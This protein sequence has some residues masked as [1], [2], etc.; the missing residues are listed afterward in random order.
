MSMSMS[1]KKLYTY[2]NF[3]YDEPG[4]EDSKIYHATYQ[5]NEETI[6]ISRS[7]IKKIKYE[8]SIFT[9]FVGKSKIPFKIH[10]GVSGEG[11]EKGVG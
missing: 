9:V 10:E 1:K 5:G 6:N 2:I 7:G 11:T 4:I 3:H 8:D